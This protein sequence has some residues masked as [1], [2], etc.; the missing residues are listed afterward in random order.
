MDLKDWTR[1]LRALHLS[2]EAFG[3]LFGKTDARFQAVAKMYAKAKAGK[4]SLD[5]EVEVEDASPESP[6]E[7][8]IPGN[9][10]MTS[11]EAK[12]LPLSTL[13][14]R[15]PRQQLKPERPPLSPSAQ[16]IL[17]PPTDEVVHHLKES[18][19]SISPRNIHNQSAHIHHEEVMN[20]STS[21]TKRSMMEDDE[22]PYGSAEEFY[23]ES[24]Q[25]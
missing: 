4:Q 7:K 8:N 18:Q 16:D 21:P 14:P 12:P 10:A 23:P 3:V 5:G 24:P 9:N 20:K 11:T 13:S 1:A 2:A 17:L 6:V 15:S 22:D 19:H 25:R